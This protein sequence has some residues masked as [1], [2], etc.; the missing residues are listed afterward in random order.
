MIL[1]RF[2]QRRLR[3]H[4][5]QPDRQ[6]LP[7][8]S[9]RHCGI[10]IHHRPLP[11]H[12]QQPDKQ[13]LFSPLHR[14][15]GYLTQRHFPTNSTPSYFKLCTTIIPSNHCSDKILLLIHTS[16]IHHGSINCKLSGQP[17]SSLAFPSY[18]VSF[19][20]LFG[21]FHFSL[22]PKPPHTRL[23]RQSSAEPFQR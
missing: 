21:P 23:V 12:S 5:Q 20:F 2:R 4:S 16:L 6:P 10:L 9:H 15:H 13:P 7:S 22:R 19:S 14:H 17:I 18:P 11:A 3:A 1:F 8:P